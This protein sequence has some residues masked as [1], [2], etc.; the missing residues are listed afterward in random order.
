M[1]NTHNITVFIWC[2]SHEND[3]AAD[4]GN[5]LAGSSDKTGHAAMKL[6]EIDCEKGD[7]YYLS[8]WPGYHPIDKMQKFHSMT[9][10]YGAKSLGA[11][12]ETLKT[13]WEAL[14][15]RQ[16]DV[17]P[18]QATKKFGTSLDFDNNFEPLLE[19]GF[20]GLGG[21]DKSSMNRLADV[22]YRMNGP[23]MAHMIEYVKG[24]T[25]YYGE[26]A[27]GVAFNIASFNCAAAVANCLDA[28]GAPDMPERKVWSP[29]R[30]AQWCEKLIEHYP[31]SQ[32]V[33]KLYSRRDG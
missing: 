11:A 21:D 7:Y 8:F 29:N 13:D 5:K 28:G 17:A 31:G 6:Q 14:R 16:D 4:A 20:P 33:G 19:G 9:G 24:I 22:K 27:T 25:S 12:N 10:R 3:I 2:N 1:A 23:N 18:V 30:L 15:D 32:Q 26:D